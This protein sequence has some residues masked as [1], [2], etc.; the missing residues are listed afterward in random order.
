M[1]NH[2]LCKKFTLF[3]VFP[4]LYTLSSLLPFTETLEFLHSPFQILA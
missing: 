1:I 4:F 3:F 2:L